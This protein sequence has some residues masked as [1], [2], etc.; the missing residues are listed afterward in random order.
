MSYFDMLQSAKEF[1]PRAYRLRY[2]ASFT[3]FF[4]VLHAYGFRPKI[5]GNNLQL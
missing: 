1:R 4:N 2:T 5:R 3:K